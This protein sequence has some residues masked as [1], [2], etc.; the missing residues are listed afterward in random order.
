MVPM[1]VLSRRKQ[2]QGVL[3]LED[4]QQIGSMNEN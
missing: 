1:V 4:V 3:T 2:D